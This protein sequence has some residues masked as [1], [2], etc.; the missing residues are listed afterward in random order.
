MYVPDIRNGTLKKVKFLNVSVYNLFV[1]KSKALKSHPDAKI[2]G[3]GMKLK[4]K[5]Q[6][7]WL[8]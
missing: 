3:L 4:Q 2:E 6:F 8:K 5:M 1:R 7:K